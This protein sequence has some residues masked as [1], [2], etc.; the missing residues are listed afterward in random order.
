MIEAFARLAAGWPARV[1][2]AA[3]GFGEAILLP[4][5][6]DLLLYPLVL[7][8]PRRAIPLLGWTVAGALLGSLV[9]SA[10]TLSDP[11]AGR[12]IVLRVP[13]I[14]Q[15]MVESAE[16]AVRDGDPLA[17]VHV[18]PGTPLKVYSIAWWE[19]SGTAPGYVLGVL[20]NRLVRIGPGI[21]L[22]AC[23]GVLAPT[24]IRRHA[25]LVVAAY[26]AFWAVVGL[27]AGR[28]EGIP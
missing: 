23:L 26:L 20:A 4:L 14:H 2:V 16:L 12:G 7:A 9:L 22:F 21:L 17:M 25:W 28:I 6:P 11:A 5:V 3:W 19:G 1:I 8:A 27:A 24:W 10:V 15:P 18:G 13:G